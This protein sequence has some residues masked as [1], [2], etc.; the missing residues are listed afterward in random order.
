LR[1]GLENQPGVETSRGKRTEDG[2]DFLGKHL[3]FMVRKCSYSGF[4]RTDLE[5]RLADSEIV[6]ICGVA[7]DC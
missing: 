7:A 4:V 1:Q 2:S 5:Q 6:L 3:S